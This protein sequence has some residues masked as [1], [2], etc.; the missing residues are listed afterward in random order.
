MAISDK[1]LTCVVGLR[2]HGHPNGGPPSAL[3]TVASVEA[4]S[5]EYLAQRLP[6]VRVREW[7]MGQ[8]TGP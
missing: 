8:G 3:A 7:L 2:H 4:E 5:G 6:D 1:T